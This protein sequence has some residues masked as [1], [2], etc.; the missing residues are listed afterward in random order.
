MSLVISPSKGTAQHIHNIQKVLLIV[1][2]GITTHMS[3]ALVRLAFVSSACSALVSL[4]LV[5]S[6]F[7]LYPFAISGLRFLCALG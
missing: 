7:G 5:S 2:Q 1:K 4:A 3:L 6:A